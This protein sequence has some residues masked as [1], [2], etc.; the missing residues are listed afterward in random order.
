M[1]SRAIKCDTDMGTRTCSTEIIS[2]LKIPILP[3]CNP[4]V[5]Q[6]WELFH[7]P[8]TQSPILGSIEP[9]H[10]DIAGNIDILIMVP[11]R[12]SIIYLFRCHHRI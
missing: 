1:F 8:R 11:L 2:I 4:K 6:T 10:V 3:P 7:V 5:T 12:C 9:H